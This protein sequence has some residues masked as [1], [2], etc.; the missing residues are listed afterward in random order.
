M[1]QVTPLELLEGVVD[2]LGLWSSTF[3][4]PNL[5]PLGPKSILAL[6]G[7]RKWGT[8]WGFTIAAHRVQPNGP[9]F[10]GLKKL[11]KDPRWTVIGIPI[12]LGNLVTGCVRPHKRSPFP[13]LPY[14]AKPVA[15][16]LKE[17]VG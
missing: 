9:T 10:Q 4:V 7:V 15:H 17:F 5:C 1:A 12:L 11:H 6:Y 13:K 8:G 3:E 16:P 2:L 14:S